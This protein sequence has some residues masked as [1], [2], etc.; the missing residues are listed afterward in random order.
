MVQTLPPSVRLNPTEISIIKSSF[1]KTFS[2]G[3]IY[4]FGSRTDNTKRGGDIDLYIQSHNLSDPIQRLRKK[5]NFQMLVKTRLGDQK[6]DVLLET[7][8]KS[9]IERVAIQQ[10]IP[11]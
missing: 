3:R 10:G 1:K 2:K 4:L 5:L 8:P 11:L 6:I 7:N 9:S